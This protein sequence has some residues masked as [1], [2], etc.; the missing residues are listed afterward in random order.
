MTKIVQKRVYA[1]NGPLVQKAQ[2]DP[3]KINLNP[4][5]LANSLLKSV[6]DLFFAFPEN[7]KRCKKGPLLYSY[8]IRTYYVI[9]TS[10]IR[11]VSLTDEMAPRV[12][13]VITHV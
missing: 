7:Q 4:K 12:M 5:F 8:Y 9:G 2:Y 10:F 6:S 13:L 3:N 11:L 1:K